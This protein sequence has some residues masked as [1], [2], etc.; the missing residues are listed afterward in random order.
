MQINTF[1]ERV[2]EK[3]SERVRAFNENKKV[4]RNLLRVS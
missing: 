1:L 4:F 2:S 3:P